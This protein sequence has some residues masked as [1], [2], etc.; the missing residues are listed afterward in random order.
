MDA[1]FKELSEVADER[2]RKASAYLEFLRVPSMS[3]GV[4][5]LPAGGVD[6]QSPHQQD[7]LYYVLGG[8]ARM[9]AGAQDRSVG[10]GTVVFVAAH[11]EH[12]F[13]DIEAELTLLV[14]FAPAEAG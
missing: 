7:E 14:F 5:V 9:R 11:V 8:K 2:A 12:R 1:C 10:P 6:N 4:Y 3:A 13:Y